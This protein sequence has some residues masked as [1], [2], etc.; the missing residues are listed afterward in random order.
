MS[1]PVPGD[2]LT[3][4]EPD[5]MYGSGELRVR[6]LILGDGKRPPHP[7]AEWIG[8]DGEQLG[9]NDAVIRHVN[10][11]VRGTALRSARLDQRSNPRS[12]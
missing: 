7:S 12:I 8:L 3:I 6:I 10:V 1:L 4:A 5:Y 2:I 11:L 9:P